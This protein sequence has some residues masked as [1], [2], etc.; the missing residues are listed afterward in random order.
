[1]SSVSRES[2]VLPISAAVLIAS[3]RL[4]LMVDVPVICE[5]YTVGGASGVPSASPP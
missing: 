3:C 2:Y 5:P 1:M 4:R